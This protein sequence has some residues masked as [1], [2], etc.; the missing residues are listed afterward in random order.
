V[1]GQ[2]REQVRALLGPGTAIGFRD[3]REAWLYPRA[4]DPRAKGKPE[5]LVLFDA[6]GRVRKSRMRAP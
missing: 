3:G 4:D 2:T 1:A 6:D 5:Y